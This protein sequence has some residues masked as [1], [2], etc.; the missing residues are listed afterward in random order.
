MFYIVSK[1]I[2][3]QYSDTILVSALI[4]RKYLYINILTMI[5]YQKIK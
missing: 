3:P 2:Q 5:L 4:Q 1:L